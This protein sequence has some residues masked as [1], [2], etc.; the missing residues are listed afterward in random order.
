MEIISDKHFRS[1]HF[2]TTLSPQ[3]NFKVN[4][5]VLKFFSFYLFCKT[6]SSWTTR[7]LWGSREYGINKKRSDSP[8]ISHSNDL[9]FKSHA[10]S[11]SMKY[12]EKNIQIGKN[13]TTWTDYLIIRNT[14]VC[15]V[16]RSPQQAVTFLSLAHTASYSSSTFKAVWERDYLASSACILEASN[17]MAFGNEYWIGRL[18][19]LVRWA[20]ARSSHRWN[21]YIGNIRGRIF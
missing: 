7:S 20:K 21:G 9:W 14:L 19:V 8:L 18:I 5:S 6:L 16:P 3:Q 10:Q 17:E 1:D 15:K 12:S 4:L 2:T 11:M 13:S